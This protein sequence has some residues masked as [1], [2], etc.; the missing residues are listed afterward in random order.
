MLYTGIRG[1]AGARVLLSPVTPK[2]TAKLWTALGAEANLGPIT[3]QP[4]RA[5]GRL[6]HAAP[7]STI[8][9]LEALFP[10]IEAEAE[11]TWTAHG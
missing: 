1:P 2:A 5:G 9:P 7:G 10:R 4:I 6:G 8:A 3:A 11:E